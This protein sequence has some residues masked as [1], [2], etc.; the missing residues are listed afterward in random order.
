MRVTIDQELRRDVA[1]LVRWMLGSSRT[2]RTWQRFEDT[3]AAMHAAHEADDAAAMENVLYELELL[4]RRVSE[5]LGQEPEEPAPKVR[6][7]ANELVH[8]LLPDGTGEDA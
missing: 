6:D 7:R 2:P 4:S 3:L 1:E 8:T 5:K